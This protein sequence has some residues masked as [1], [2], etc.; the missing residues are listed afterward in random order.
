MTYT[1]STGPTTTATR[2]GSGGT[3]RRSES[4]GARA[5]PDPV[6]AR[7]GEPA[8][9]RPAGRSAAALSGAR[10]Q[11]QG[12]APPAIDFARQRGR[13]C[14]MKPAGLAVVVL[15]SLAAG[16]GGGG[17]NRV[18]VG[19]CGVAPCGGD[20]AGD[21]AASSV[22]IES[23]AVQ[24]GHP[25]AREGV[26]SGAVF[27]TVT[28]TPSGMLSL[29][30]DMSFT[31]SLVVNT[32]VKLIYPATCVTKAGAVTMWPRRCGRDGRPTGSSGPAAPAPTRAPVRRR[33]RSTS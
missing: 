13:V 26:L 21:W 4:S 3:T 8:A 27:G 14:L 30:A 5:K 11:K 18:D 28:L 19:T 31:G 1:L 16:C 25:A 15:S 9:R 6:S 24:H 2:R 22:C 33:G 23:G 29:A 10:D 20:V 17:G 12:V 7:P 32:A